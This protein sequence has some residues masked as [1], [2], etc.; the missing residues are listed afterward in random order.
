M[1]YPILILHGWGWPISSPQW[2][3]V[4]DLLEEKGYN[5]FVP[6]LPGFGKTP[7]PILPWSLDDY[8]EW[9]KSYC[10][11][12]NFAKFFLLGHSFGGSLAAKFAIKYPQ[13]VEK[14]ILIDAAGIRK[15]RLKKEIQK[16]VAHLLNKFSF[17]PFYSLARRIAYRTLFL[18]SDY[19]LTGGVMKE[20]YLKVLEND[21]SDIF[22]SVAVPTALI[23]GEK[24]NITPLKHALFMKKSIAGAYLEIIPGVKHNPHKESPEILVKKILEFIQ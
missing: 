18:H 14:L 22:S 6:D 17:L 10:E 15:K 5:V 7:P 13:F 16:K 19:L 23:W 3:R 24:D 9:V 12:K 8:V 2:A 21:I 4:K 11:Q 20:T 1:S